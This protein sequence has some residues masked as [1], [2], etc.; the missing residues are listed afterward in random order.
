[1]KLIIDEL[2]EE[3]RLDAYLAE[4]LQD[5]S[6][7]KIQSEIKSGNIKVNSKESKSS[8]IIKCGDVIDFDDAPNSVA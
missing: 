4:C 6:R 7:S 2:T 3:K 5:F 1:M 8:Y